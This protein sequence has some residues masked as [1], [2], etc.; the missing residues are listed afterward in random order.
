MVIVLLASQK[1]FSRL[2]QLSATDQGRSK[3]FSSGQAKKWVRLPQL[4][5][6]NEQSC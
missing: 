5:V 4:W 1:T 3:R 2:V 6:E